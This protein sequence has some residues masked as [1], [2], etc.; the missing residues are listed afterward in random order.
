MKVFQY[1]KSKW[2]VHYVLFYDLLKPFWGST[3]V[4]LKENLCIYLLF[5]F[6]LCKHREEIF[7]IHRFNN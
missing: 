1:K 2:F 4:N 6:L 3:C 7:S 5:L